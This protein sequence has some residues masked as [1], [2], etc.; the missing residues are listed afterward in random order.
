[1]SFPMP[2]H[3]SRNKV[4]RDLDTQLNDP[5]QR[6]E[7]YHLRLQGT[8]IWD[9]AVQMGYATQQVADHLRNHFY[10]T[11]PNAYWPGPDWADIGDKEEI[12][13]LGYMRAIETAG[14]DL[15]DPS[16]TWVPRNGNGDAINADD[17]VI[18]PYE[19]PIASYWICAG[20]RFEVAIS[21]TDAQVTL[22]I[23]TP[24]LPD[25]PERQRMRLPN[26][27]DIHAVAVESKIYEFVREFRLD[28]LLSSNPAEKPHYY[29]GADNPQKQLHERYLVLRLMTD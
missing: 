24:Y 11:G 3:I 15:N 8:P 23:M 27:D 14:V 20:A 9:I 12:V 25:L 6:I 16:I 19:L 5:A 28:Q 22:M 10:G 21:R 13:R 26:P 2:G 1:M 4:L 29:R 18:P 7:H 17:E